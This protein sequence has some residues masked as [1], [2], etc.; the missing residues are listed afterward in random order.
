MKY[1]QARE[2][3]GMFQGLQLFLIIF[4]MNFKYVNLFDEIKIYYYY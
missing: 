3:S 2:P 1:A 4:F